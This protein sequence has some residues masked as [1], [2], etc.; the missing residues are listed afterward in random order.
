MMQDALSLL[1]LYTEWGVD[2]AVTDQATDHR[3]TGAGAFRLPAAPTRAGSGATPGAP[4]AGPH[5]TH[6]QPAPPQ[7]HPMAATPAAAA[8]VTSLGESIALAQHAA[9]QATTPDALRAAIEGFAACSLHATAMHTLAP[10]GPHNAPLMLI[11]EAPDA[12]EDRSG[13][14]FAGLCGSLL[15]ALL[16]PLPLERS[17]LA[18]ATALPWRPP[19]GRP[20]SDAEQRICVPF[21]QRAITLFAPRRLVLCGRLPATM[22]LGRD[23][24]AQRREW[25]A[26][27]LP[28]GPTIP[29][30]VMRHPLQLRASPTARREIWQTLM[31]VMK[32]LRDDP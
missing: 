15:D 9:A 20:P 28:D 13:Q 11:G 25:S 23:T 19:G 22:L 21:L 14:V 16:A 2:T 3:Q 31:M 12:D 32:T 4:A 8:G 1:R 29:A 30:V 18:L 5:H 6:H 7:T 24:P 26:L 27:A 17:Q 10:T